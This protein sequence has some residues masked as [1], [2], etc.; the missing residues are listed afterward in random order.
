MVVV[1]VAGV[2]GAGG[3]EEERRSGPSVDFLPLSCISSRVV[4]PSFF[5]WFAGV[6]ISLRSSGSLDIDRSLSYSLSL[7]SLFL[8]LLVGNISFPFVPLF[9]YFTHR[10]TERHAHTLFSFL[11]LSPLYSSPVRETLGS[12]RR[13]DRK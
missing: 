10:D 8:D 13:R 9:L 1:G 4:P 12:S 2:V 5:S 3:G 7:F 11:F 6:V